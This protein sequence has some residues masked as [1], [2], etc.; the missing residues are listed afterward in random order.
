MSILYGVVIIEKQTLTP[1][2]AFFVL[3][4]FD[5]ISTSIRVI[6]S[7]LKD[8]I[9]AWS[10]LHRIVNFLNMEESHK[11]KFIEQRVA[12]KGELTGN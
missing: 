3:Y 2:L 7:M 12:E 1:E 5:Q 9:E 11:E 10:S 8:P 6:P 4:L